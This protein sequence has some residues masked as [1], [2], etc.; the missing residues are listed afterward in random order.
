MS[1]PK[2]LVDRAVDLFTAGL[3]CSQAS[4]A[5][6]CEHWSL[7]GTAKVAACFG[8]GIGRTGGPCGIITGCLMALGLLAG[9]DDPKDQETKERVTR[10]ARETL[11]A[12]RNIQ[13]H[14]DCI[15]LTGMDH[16]TEEGREEFTRRGLKQTVCIPLMRSAMVL[17]DGVA[18]KEGL[19]PSQG[20]KEGSRAG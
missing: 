17:M 8:G 7:P 15:G 19:V 6:L 12:F 13:G 2:R 10:L 16:S 3:N 20:E 18:R 14:S 9:T 11:A 1:D 5:A 4:F